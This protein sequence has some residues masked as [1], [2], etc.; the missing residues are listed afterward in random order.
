[1]IGQEISHYKILD[2]LGSGGMGVVYKAHDNKLDRKVALKFILPQIVKKKRNALKFNQEARAAAS[3]NH[4]HICTVYEIDEQEGNTFIA[5]EYIKGPSLRELT[6]KGLLELE[7]ALAFSIQIAEGLQEAHEKGIIHRDIKSSNII[8]TRKNQIKIMDFGLAKIKG[9]PELSETRTLKGTVSYMSPEQASGKK[10]D[11]RTDI[12]SLG[13]VM[14]EMLSG[15]LPF[16]SSHQQLV[17]NSILKE[18]PVS[19]KKLRRNIPYRLEKI[20]KKCLNKDPDRRY[21]NMVEL[22]ADLKQLKEEIEKGYVPSTQKT[23]MTDITEKIQRH[24]KLIAPM[25]F[26]ASLLLITGGYFISRWF[27]KPLQYKKSIAVLPFEGVIP[28]EEDKALCFWLT[29]GVIDRLAKLSQELRVVP[30]A[31]VEKYQSPLDDI[32]KIGSN[33]KV[34]HILTAKVQTEAKK[35]RIDAELISV[36]DERFIKAY[37]QESELTDYLVIQDEISKSVVEDMGVY[38]R[39]SGLIQA[40]KRESEKIEASLLY[41]E[42]WDIL[43]KRSQFSSLDEW[44]LK[45]INKFDQ[46][47]AIDPSFALAYWGKGAVHEVCYVETKQRE[48]LLQTMKFFEKAHDLNPDLAETNISLGW[49]H[50]YKEDLSESY[51]SFKRALEIGPYDPLVITDAGAFLASIGL[52]RPAIGLFSRAIQI[53]PSYLRAYLHKASCHWY[54]GEFEEGLK[55]LEKRYEIEKDNPQI[56]LMCARNLIMMDRFDQAQEEFNEIM[57][58][59]PNNEGY[60]R[61]YKALLWAK[62]GEKD[63][64]LE[65]IKNSDNRYFLTFTCIYSLLGMKDEAIDNILFGIENGFQKNQQY[66][67]SFPI[68]DRHPCYDN[69]RKNPRVVEILEQQRERYHQNMKKYGDL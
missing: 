57:K 63:R 59:N 15:C 42:G 62:K 8:V 21:Q 16:E 61:I 12:W 45:A 67:Y 3:L 13:V 58:L 27:E 56:H 18:E 9:D 37:S 26:I 44:F 39:E 7:E 48:S 36:K 51:K 24:K 5:M 11:H 65:F 6:K 53:E 19:L 41:Q 64:A 40:R 10:I 22:K 60:L 34:Q 68:L 47:L 28:E 29:K 32:S 55:T 50:F 66:M 52:Y 33:L 1:M 23:D 4:P 30:F 35:V 31:S 20:V 17:L 69:I 14:Y 2:E 43:Y 46:A 49:A 25:V 38:F 54:I